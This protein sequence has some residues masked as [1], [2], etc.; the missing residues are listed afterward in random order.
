VLRAVCYW[1]VNPR[2]RSGKL[3]VNPTPGPV[4]K[5]LGNPSLAGEDG[6]HLSG[7]AAHR[8]RLALLALLALSPG[9]RVSRDKLMGLLWPERASGEARN[10]LK[11]SAYVI[12]QALGEAALLSDGDSMRLNTAVLRVDVVD[13]KAALDRGDHEGAVALYDGPLLNG[14]FLSGAPEF[15]QEMDR[16]RERLA[17]ACAGALESLAQDAEADGDFRAAAEWWKVRAAHDPYD[18]RVAVSL[19]RAMAAVGNRAGALQHAAVHARL[20]QDELELE[21]AA[22]VIALTEELRTMGA[23]PARESIGLDAASGP[24]RE[25]ESVARAAPPQRGPWRR[26]HLLGLVGLISLVMVAGVWWSRRSTALVIHAH[27]V[28]VA[29]LENR[30]GDSGLDPLGAMAADWITQGLSGTGIVEVVPTSAGLASARHVQEAALGTPL[31]D[32]ARALAEQTGAGLVIWGAYYQTGDSLRFQVHITDARQGRILQAVEPIGAATADPMPAIELVRRR[33]LGALAPFLDDRLAAHARVTSQPPSHEAYR[34]YAEGMEVFIQSRWQESIAHFERSAALDTSYLTPRLLIAI[35]H[36][37]R[38]AG[39]LADSIGRDLDRKRERLGPYDRALLDLL[40]SWL[41]HD[42]AAR[43][44]AARR[45]A[46]LAPETLPHVQ[47][48]MEAFRMNRPREAIEIL[49]GIDPM[50]GEVRGWAHYW[51]T[52]AGAHHML[53]D[54][55]KELR[56]ARRAH[57]LHPDDPRYL[58]TEGMALAARGRAGELDRV[59]AARLSLPVDRTPD[60]GSMKLQLAHELRVHGHPAAARAL[61][62]RA[63][64]WYGDRSVAEP[65]RYR[66]SEAFAR[67]FAQDWGEAERL[68]GDV[69]ADL[70]EDVHIQGALGVLAARR[71]DRGEAERIRSWLTGPGT[72]QPWAGQGPPGRR[73]PTYWRACIAAHEGRLE[74][75]LVLLR[76][77]F[78][79]GMWYDLLPH[80]DPCLDPLRSHPAFRELFRPRMGH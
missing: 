56:I 15:D 55:R 58:L 7:R 65:D 73:S 18:S 68:L 37:N 54:H 16:E 57:A 76:R 41:S 63:L 8:H 75:A 23:A 66:L 80:Q 28:V 24:P 27:R 36:S 40:L 21:P 45:A 17:G 69:A 38:G 19:M 4:L 79:E 13:F 11:V 78:G 22:E 10:L 74:E 30:T 77:S 14:F 64:D 25:P 44:H 51:Q 2:C 5:L 59:I 3:T 42:Q 43:Y 1:W 70:P 39:G 49:S 29:P 32:V 20:L 60:P 46:A 9:H 35:A 47:W 52:L 33:T 12:R 72:T 61:Y 53:G 48:G 50:R 67:F 31:I 62:R 6:A 34:A 71:G 26:L